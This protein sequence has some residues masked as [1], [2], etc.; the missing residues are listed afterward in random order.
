MPR[1][2]STV[3]LLAVLS[4]GDCW[5]LDVLVNQV[6]YEPNSPKVVRVQRATDSPSA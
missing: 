5:A 1:L 4:T 6:G 2:L 3:L